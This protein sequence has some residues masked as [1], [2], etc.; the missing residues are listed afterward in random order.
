MANRRRDPHKAAFWRQVVARWRRSGQG[1]R[2]FCAGAGLSEPFFYS[3]RRELAA[4]DQR[5]AHHRARARKRSTMAPRFVP[6]RV[7]PSPRPATAPLEVVLG[8]GRVLRIV[9]GFDAAL[10]RQL[11][12]VL[13]APPC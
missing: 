7:V 8:N 4:R 9:A 3:W 1:V 2:E 13:E 11:L 6:V 10:L 5:Q 12:A